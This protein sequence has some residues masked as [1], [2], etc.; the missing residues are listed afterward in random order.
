MVEKYRGAAPTSLAAPTVNYKRSLTPEQDMVFG[1]IERAML[2]AFEDAW[3]KLT[4]VGF[5]AGEDTIYCTA[6]DCEQFVHRRGTPN[7]GRCGHSWFRHNV[8]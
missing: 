4:V 8:W 5:E 1:Q 7:C 2:P 6:C 3:T